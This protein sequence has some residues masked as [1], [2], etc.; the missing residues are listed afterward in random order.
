MVSDEEGGRRGEVAGGS[1]NRIDSLSRAGV[2]FLYC[3]PT[4]DRAR[5][6]LPLSPF[7]SHPCVIYLSAVVYVDGL[8]LARKE[9]YVLLQHSTPSHVDSFSL[10]VSSTFSSPSSFSFA[11]RSGLLKAL[12]FRGRVLVPIPRGWTGKLIGIPCDEHTTV[13]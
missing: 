7:P 11:G 6:K 1:T 13:P 3:R 5:G 8:I 2:T 9:P 4:S 12:L 10:S